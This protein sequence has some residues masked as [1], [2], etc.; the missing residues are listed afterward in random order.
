[1]SISRAKRLTIMCI[2]AY[3]YK[4]FRSWFSGRWNSLGGLQ[5]WPPKSPDFSPKTYTRICRG[6]YWK[7]SISLSSS[8]AFLDAAT[9]TKKILMNRWK[10]YSRFTISPVVI[11]GWELLFRT[12]AVWLGKIISCKCACFVFTFESKTW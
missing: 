2:P 8:V 9:C 6:T 7:N 1:M 10:L 12:F 5:H 3:Q 4:L 11:W